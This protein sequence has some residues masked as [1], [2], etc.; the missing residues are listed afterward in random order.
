MIAMTEVSCRHI[1]A[2]TSDDPA[3]AHLGQRIQLQADNIDR[4]LQVALQSHRRR[5][6]PLAHTLH[7]PVSAGASYDP[8]AAYLVATGCLDCWLKADQP[9]WQSAGQVHAQKTRAT[10]V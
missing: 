7:L 3:A 9:I 10:Y 5:N 1:S 2:D 6:Q 4:A 8:T